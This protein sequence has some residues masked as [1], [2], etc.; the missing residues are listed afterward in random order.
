MN[1]AGN[2]INHP[3]T[4]ATD[5]HIAGTPLPRAKF[6]NSVG[7]FA[8]Q[9]SACILVPMISTADLNQPKTQV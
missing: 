7:D 1:R 3:E 5:K 9:E 8:P 6:V 4:I 2:A